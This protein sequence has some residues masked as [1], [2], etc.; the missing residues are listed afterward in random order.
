M[1]KKGIFVLF[2]L[3]C[4]LL[5]VNNV[6]ASSYSISNSTDVTTISKMVSGKIPMKNGEFIKNGDVVKFN[7]GNYKNIKLVVNKKIVLTKSGNNKVNF[8]GN[9]SGIAIK[10]NSNKIKINGLRIKNYEYGIYGKITSS[11][12]SKT[13]LHGS[14]IKIVGKYNKFSYNKLS[15]YMEVSGKYNKIYLNKLYGYS[16]SVHGFKNTILKN[17]L[18]GSKTYSIDVSGSNNLITS[19]YM[20]GYS[21][22]DSTGLSISDGSNN[23]FYYNTIIKAYW[24]INIFGT[25]NVFYKNKIYRCRIGIQYEDKTNN[26]I[27]NI[28]KKNKKNILFSPPTTGPPEGVY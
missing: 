21:S 24:G 22:S 16:I 27:K 9:G 12:I 10:V 5:I 18:V 14:S 2:G 1:F 17:R 6:S 23:K 15:G 3:L 13:I 4:I 19:N 25:K 7:A 8:I 11:S 26:C 28:F 20:H